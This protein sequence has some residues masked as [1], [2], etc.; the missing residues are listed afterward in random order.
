M[1]DVVK[2]GDVV[3]VEPAAAPPV[4][5]KPATAASQAAHLIATHPGVDHLVLR[6]VPLVQAALVSLDPATGRVVALVGGWNFDASQFN[7]ATQAK[8]QPGSSFKPFVYLTALEHGISPSQQF[9]DAPVVVDQGPGLGRWR[10]NN[11]E[12]DFRGPTPLR[13]ALEQSINLVTIR[14]AAYLGMDSVADTAIAF[15]M[16]DSMPRV[17]PAA[18]GAVD[19]TP[20]REAAAYASI[21]AGGREVVPSLIDSVQDRDGHDVWRPSGVNCAGCDDAGTPP[22]LVDDRRQIADPA[23]VYQLINMMEGVVQRGTGVPAGAGLN[24]PI[25]GK[26]GTTQ[27]FADA[28]FSGFT[29][30]LVT[31]VWVG[32]DNP[33]TLGENETGAAIAAPIWHDF[34]AVALKDRPPL[35]FAQPP[36]VTMGQ[37]DSGSGMVTDAFKPG[38]VPGAS[39]PL[40]AGADILHSVTAAATSDATSTTADSTTAAAP[41][42]VSG[43]IDSS[44]GGLY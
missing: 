27:E 40:I 26:T 18:I 25:A 38:Q 39:D 41:R 9:L 29:A 4:A 5:A 44:M 11:F 43:G 33:A 2:P 30:D 15:H 19:T 8:R 10:P 32:Y 28:W 36:G 37:W 17:L 23:S 3:M 13:V 1:G 31:V 35:Q 24:H 34:M 20:M 21:D 42:P 7:R 12:R 6:Q 22:Q 14:V 16:V